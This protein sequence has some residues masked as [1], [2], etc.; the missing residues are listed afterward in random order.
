MTDGKPRRQDQEGAVR[1][2]YCVNCLEQYVYEDQ[3]S[4]CSY[5]P[6]VPERE[7]TMGARD[8]YAIV[9]R[10]PCCDQEVVGAVTSDGRD[11]PPPKTPGCCTG[12]HRSSGT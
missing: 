8:N 5:H 2:G 7:Q 6:A 9:W 12:S 11:L 10:Y 3:Q 1:L 4:V